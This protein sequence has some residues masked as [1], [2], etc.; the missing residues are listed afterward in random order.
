MRYRQIKPLREVKVGKASAQKRYLSELGAFLAMPQVLKQE[1]TKETDFTKLESYI[2]QSKIGNIGGFKKELSK[3]TPFYTEDPENLIYYINQYKPQVQKIVTAGYT[4]PNTYD[5]VI[6]NQTEGASDIF[7]NDSDEVGIS[8]KAEGGITLSSPGMGDFNF[9]QEKGDKVAGEAKPEYDTWVQS[10]M[11]AVIA[12]AMKQPLLEPDTDQ[13][14]TPV[15]SGPLEKGTLKKAS[16]GQ[17]YE[18]AG[19]Q[20]ISKSTGRIA[21]T[22]IAT[23]LTPKA[24]TPMAQKDGARSPY[25]PKRPHSF[26]QYMGSGK[27]NIQGKAQ[28]KSK[29]LTMTEEQILAE[30]GTNPAHHRCFGDWYIDFGAKQD[31]PY[32]MPFKRSV[33]VKLETILENFLSVQENVRKILQMGNQP[34]FYMTPKAVAYVPSVQVIPDILSTT[35]PI[36]DSKGGSG[37]LFHAN[38]TTKTKDEKIT[39][40]DYATADIYFRW[41]NGL[42][43]SPS[44]VA[45]QNLKNYQALGWKKL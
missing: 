17:D 45:V 39:K 37:I 38:F 5:L 1:L 10:C 36:T 6:G 9:S 11:K 27:F 3:A 40:D 29:L 12:E 32:M 24:T 4:L 2:N 15:Q 26:I 8:V 28:S 18:W 41:R 30:A 22:N 23:E 44:T 20:W 19:A 42:F 7:F 35:K 13:S 16:D 34:Y 33:T 43:A 25:T 21:T 31:D 14:N